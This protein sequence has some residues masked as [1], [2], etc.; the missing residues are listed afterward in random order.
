MDYDYLEQFFRAYVL[1]GR[2]LGNDPQTPFWI[3]GDK[4][5]AAGKELYKE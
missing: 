4:Y 1:A 5:E 3:T 2:L